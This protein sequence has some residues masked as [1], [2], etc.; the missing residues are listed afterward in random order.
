MWH[1]VFI[2]FPR[3]QCKTPCVILTALNNNLKLFFSPSFVIFTD[4]RD[5][6]LM[7]LR[8]QVSVC[9]WSSN[10]ISMWMSSSQMSTCIFWHSFNWLLLMFPSFILYLM[11]VPLSLRLSLSLTHTHMPTR[12]FL[13]PLRSALKCCLSKQESGLCPGSSRGHSSGDF[14]SHS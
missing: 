11:K 5:R 10:S 4:I 12:S 1:I 8:C 7:K 14:I 9:G 6:H 3:W 2:S 13:A